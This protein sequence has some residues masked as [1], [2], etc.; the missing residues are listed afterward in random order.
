MKCVYVYEIVKV[1]DDEKLLTDSDKIGNKMILDTFDGFHHDW[2]VLS[3][4]GK[5]LFVRRVK[6]LF[7]LKKDVTTKEGLNELKSKLQQ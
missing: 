7:K 5:L 1:T 6:F 4:K 2:H 3:D